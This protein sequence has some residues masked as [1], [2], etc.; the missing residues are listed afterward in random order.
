MKS[1]IV[2]TL[3]R[4]F[5]ERGSGRTNQEFTSALALAKM[6]PDK[7]YL[8]ITSD[9]YTNRNL[10]DRF[11]EIPRNLTVSDWI[12]VT[13]TNRFRGAKFNE[14]FIDHYVIETQLLPHLVKTQGAENEML[15][16]ELEQVKKQRDIW[17]SDVFSAGQDIRRLTELLSKKDEEIAKLRR[18]LGKLCDHA[19]HRILPSGKSSFLSSADVV[20]N[21]YC[22]KCGEKL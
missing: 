3:M 4:N 12:S 18:Q 21:D 1:D 20:P 14:V 5:H 22:P 7:T 19:T 11:P 16:E 10:V 15:R 6:H 9:I 17:Q 2:S 8:Y 13:Q